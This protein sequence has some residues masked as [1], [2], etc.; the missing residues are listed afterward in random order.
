MKKE[1]FEEAN[2]LIKDIKHMERQLNEVEKNHHWIS[3]STP[4][5][6]D[7]PYSI[8][9]QEELIKWMSEKKTEY[10]QRFNKL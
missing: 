1:V 4:D 6:P 10:Q 8:M 2:A 5:Y 3:I 9:F 7:S